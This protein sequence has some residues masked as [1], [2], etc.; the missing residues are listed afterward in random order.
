MAALGAAALAYSASRIA[1]PSSAFTPGA[2]QLF[3]PLGG[4]GCVWLN[5][6]EY[7]DNPK[8][9]RNVLQSAAEYRSVS[10]IST[11]VWPCPVMPAV[12]SE[13]HTSELQSRRDLVCRLLLEKKKKK[14]VML[15]LGP[16]LKQI[17]EKY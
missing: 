11:I 15:R 10:S 8:V 12:R 5:E 3:G 2:P 4:A 6:P 16:P 7:P 1:S 14:P 13:E 17:A 9:D